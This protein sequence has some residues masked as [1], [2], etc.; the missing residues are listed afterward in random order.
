MAMKIRPELEKRSSRYDI[1]RP[2][3]RHGH[4]YAKYKIC[5]DTVMVIC[6]K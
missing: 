3:C 1:N 5:L 2:R 6:I 4:K